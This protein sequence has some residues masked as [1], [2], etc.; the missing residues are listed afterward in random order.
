M[1]Y[2]QKETIIFDKAEPLRVTTLCGNNLLEHV[3]E[4]KYA[5]T[6][7]V[8]WCVFHNRLSFFATGH[9]KSSYM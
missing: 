2:R 3:N 4:Y 9:L 8:F 5:G 6:F 1:K 7:Y